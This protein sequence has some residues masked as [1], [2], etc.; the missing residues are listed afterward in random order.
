MSSDEVRD[1]SLVRPVHARMA[2]YI[3]TVQIRPKNTIHNITYTT[4]YGVF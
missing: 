3:F 4:M 1:D 2:P